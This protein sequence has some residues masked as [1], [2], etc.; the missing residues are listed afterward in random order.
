ML[1]SDYLCEGNFVLRKNTENRIQIEQN[2]DN[3]SNK[4][5]SLNKS[6][7]NESVAS[8]IM[9]MTMSQKQQERE[10]ES[11]DVTNSRPN[12]SQKYRQFNH[13]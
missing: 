4:R 2:K 6:G 7:E 13:P 10:L 5:E 12:F 3:G 8:E 9:F 1:S 11:C